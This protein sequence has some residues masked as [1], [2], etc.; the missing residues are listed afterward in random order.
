MTVTRSSPSLEFVD[1]NTRIPDSCRVPYPY[2]NQLISISQRAPLI[3]PNLP[4]DIET[5]TSPLNVAEWQEHLKNH[6][7]VVFKAFILAGISSGFRLG[8]D[9]S[10]QQQLKPRKGNLLSTTEHPDVV[11]N[12]IQNELAQG[13]LIYVPNPESLP[14]VHS[15]P[16]GVI[17]KKHKPGK[18]RLIVDLSA[19]DKHAVNSFIEKEL[20]SLSYISVDDVAQV[21][22]KLGKGTLLAKV[23]VKEA[24]RIIPVHPHDRLLLGMLWDSKLYLD[25]CL[26]FGL[27]SAPLLFTAL[28]D[29][30]EWVLRQHGINQVFHYIDDFILAGKPAS[31]ECSE[32]LARTL[33]IFTKLG[34]PVEP[35][36]LEGPATCI[37]ILG[38]EVDTIKQELRL[39]EDKLARLRDLTHSW[40][41]QKCCKK[42]DLLSL[43]GTLQHAASV[44]R[45]GRAFV[46][47]MIDLSTSRN[48]ME[49]WLRLNWEFRSDLEWWFQLASAWNGV[50]LLAPLRRQSPDLELTT[51]ASGSWGCGAFHEVDWFQLQWEEKSEPPN[52]TVKELTPIVLAAALWGHKWAGKT[53]R[54][55][56]DNMAVV[57]ILN[58]RTSKD[59]NAMHLVR[60]LCLI[61]CYCNFTIVS[62]HIPGSHN[63]LADALSRNNTAHFLSHLPQAASKATPLPKHLLQLL[64]TQQPDWTSVL[65]ANQFKTTIFKA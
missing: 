19:P 45:P 43:I 4:T 63:D 38:I 53:I 48:H 25:K 42:R 55:R 6:P 40:R 56:C 15:S 13:R 31:N 11:D 60:C 8:F 33:Q 20:C 23:D 27:R 18:W 39:P 32:H 49:A 21:I 9:Y 47:R 10:H 54:A 37:T 65:W 24:F 3:P 2:L 14:W 44:V 46:R 22:L 1:V 5:I 29:A 26:P 41:G 7:D 35:S 62:K 12:Y 17:P 30:L 28:A 50:S 36:K 16:F 34:I 57:H 61:E 52:I 51:D 59:N 64:I 58:S